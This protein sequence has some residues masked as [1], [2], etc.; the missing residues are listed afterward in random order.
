MVLERQA[1]E[2]GKSYKFMSCADVNILQKSAAGKLDHFIYIFGWSRRR[3]E[4]AFDGGI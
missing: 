1:L 3:S 4:A 2:W